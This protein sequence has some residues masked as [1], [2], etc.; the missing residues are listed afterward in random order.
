LRAR[1]DEAGRTDLLAVLDAA[2]ANLDPTLLGL[3]AYEFET[4][5]P[6]QDRPREER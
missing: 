6:N 1:L 5:A 2:L 3:P 4:P